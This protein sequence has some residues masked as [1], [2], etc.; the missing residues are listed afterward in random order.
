MLASMSLGATKAK[1]HIT[2]RYM[3]NPKLPFVRFKDERSDN[4][5]IS[6]RIHDIINNSPI[7]VAF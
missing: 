4:N 1:T 6:W 3:I 7:L 2:F 5:N